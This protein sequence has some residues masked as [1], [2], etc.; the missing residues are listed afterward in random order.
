VLHK[1]RDEQFVSII[2][3]YD[4][5]LHILFSLTSLSELYITRRRNRFPPGRAVWQVAHHLSGVIHA[6]EV[7][8]HQRVNETNA[9]ARRVE[10]VAPIGVY[11]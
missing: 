1:Q 4:F 10:P 6:V 7:N 11:A 2:P 5:N 8:R 3:H 9:E